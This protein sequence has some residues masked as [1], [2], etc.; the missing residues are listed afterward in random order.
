MGTAEPSRFA[1]GSAQTLTSVVR[2][3]PD[4]SG[5]DKT[6]DYV[7][8]DGVDTVPIGSIVRVELH[9]RRVDAWVVDHVSTAE[10]GD[11]DYELKPLLAFLS[12]GP[13]SATVD[14]ARW[15]AYRCAG[16]LRAVLATA[17]PDKRVKTL[18]ASARRASGRS[19]PADRAI[20]AEADELLS[21]GGGVLVLP[22]MRP[23][24]PVLESA[25]RRGPVLVVCPAVSFGRTI[26]TALRREGLSVALMPDDWQR[27]AEGV[28]VV[29]GARSAVWAPCVDVASIVVLDEH[30]ERLQDERSPTWHVRDI[31]VE[32]ASRAGVPC[33]LVS[34]LPTA[35]ALHWAGEQRTTVVEASDGDW[36]HI[37]VVDPF[38]DVADQRSDDEAPKFGLVSS[39]LMAELRDPTRT[40]VC[41]LNVKGRARLLACKSCHAVARCEHCDA[42]MRDIGTERL[43][44]P[45]CGHQRPFV[46]SGCGSGALSM[47]RKGVTRAA[48]EIA[49]A[50]NRPV[51]DITGSTE[52][53]SNTS[54]G[55]YV[56]T[57]AVLHRVASADVVAFLDFDN[58]V[59][60]PTYRAAEHAWS[61][62][63]LAARLLRSAPNGRIILQSNDAT[64]P[65]L[66]EFV[67][68]DPRRVLDAEMSKRRELSLPPFSHMM[69]VLVDD[70]VPPVLDRPPLGIAVARS[71]KNAYLVKSHDVDLLAEFAQQVRNQH[72]RVHADPPRY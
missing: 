40:V 39:S 12:V 28:D 3:V 24:R 42:A 14:L 62:I 50:A 13:S 2:V 38:T 51:R 68:P 57:E 21:R 45:A 41:V 19:A 37:D 72:A 26:A 17:S 36:P 52:T 70:H 53:A 54:A 44:C 34:P 22:P 10:I 71:G 27:A 56:G 61:L 16:P 31:A 58:E 46:C 4:V 25:L 69:R 47:L 5:I 29:V 32:R 9:G 15:A 33:L 20:S 6:F 18:R 11:L 1:E 59:F 60:A 67:A 65:L 43:E 30:D 63:V 66:R 23:I 35:S 55:I 49:A 48:E 7:V 8:P 64:N